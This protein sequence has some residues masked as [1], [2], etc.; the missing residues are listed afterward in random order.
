MFEP[1][2][3]TIRQGHEETDS[4]RPT[5]LR[6]L[7]GTRKHDKHGRLQPLKCDLCKVLMRIIRREAHPTRGPQYE[8][9]TFK[10]PTCGRGD[11]AIVQSRGAS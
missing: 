5:Q 6:P 11:V 7:Y 9:Q 3:W 8:L 2:K 1:K 4:L 10:C